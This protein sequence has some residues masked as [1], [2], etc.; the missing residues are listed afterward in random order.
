[1]SETI[2]MNDFCFGYKNS[3]IFLIKDIYLYLLI[4]F[5]SVYETN[6]IENRKKI[7]Y[8]DNTT[9]SIIH[10]IFAGLNTRFN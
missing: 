5:F 2:T 10:I 6:R 7:S 9:L 8:V 4:K 3:F 1:M